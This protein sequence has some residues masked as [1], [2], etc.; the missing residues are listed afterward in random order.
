MWQWSYVENLAPDTQKTAL[1]FGTGI[2]HGLESRYPPGLKRGPHPAEAFEAWY[3]ANQEDFWAWDDEGNRIDALELGI[4]MLRGYVREYG[5]DKHL[6]IIQPEQVFEFHVY[7]KHGNY[8]GTWCGTG[9]ALAIDLSKSTRKRRVIVFLE[10]KTTK[11]TPPEEVHVLSTYGEQGHS[12]HLGGSLL[13]RAQGLLPADEAVDSVRF[14]W[15]K[16]ALPDTRPTNS[17]GY[18]VNKPKKEALQEYLISNGHVDTVSELRG[19]KVPEL[20]EMVSVHFNPNNLAEI[21]KRQPSK[22][23]H[24]QDMDLGDNLGELMEWRVMADMYEMDM[25]R[26]GLLPITKNP[27]DMNCRMCPFFEMCELH[28]MGE[29]WEAMKQFYVHED[30]NSVY[31]K[32]I[33]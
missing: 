18:A 30:P 12:Y 19:V 4:E 22:L 33:K 16:K 24:R 20:V 8:V 32:E 23:F 28:E 21:S 17:D 9:D 3:E 2:H 13:A 26:K 10:H 27:T 29:D 31:D 7:D 1:T 5:E 6:E 15:L 11:A 14:N 25:A